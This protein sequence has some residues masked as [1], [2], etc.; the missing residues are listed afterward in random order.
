MAEGSAPAAKEL[1][2]R[3]PD[4]VFKQLCRMAEDM[5]ARPETFLETRVA[6]LV[7][8]GRRPRRRP[9][10]EADQRPGIYL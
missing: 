6:L 2:I 5:G 8:E 4:R 3:V 7:R 10:P 1:R 9:T